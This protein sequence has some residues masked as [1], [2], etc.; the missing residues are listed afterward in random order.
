VLENGIVN[1]E[2][3]S[4]AGHVMSYRDLPFEKHFMYSKSDKAVKTIPVQVCA[5]PEGFRRMRSSDLMKINT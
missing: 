2:I 4:I 5:Y 3:C 1:A